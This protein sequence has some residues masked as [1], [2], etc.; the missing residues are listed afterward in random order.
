MKLSDLDAW[1]R[2]YLDLD[3][4]EQIDA[5][6][7]GLQVARKAQEV[8]KVAFSVDASLE[9]FRRAIEQGAQMLFVHHG[10]LWD[11]QERFVGAFY[12]RLRALMEG[13]LALYA[14]HL[15]LDQHP[16]VGNNIG[17]ANH[18]GLQNMEPFGSYRGTK[19][20]YKGTL[21]V[22]ARL[23]EV[24]LR[25]TGGHRGQGGQSERVNN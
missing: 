3:S 21:P 9:T 10:I 6:R 25:L 18:L 5:S 2:K 17:I 7:N 24:V 4:F 22:P 1:L 20:G 14:A 12:E 8:T 16:E 15:P 11:R 19:I 13:D 23:D